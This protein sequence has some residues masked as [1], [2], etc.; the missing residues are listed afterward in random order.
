LV[1]HLR[2]LMREKLFLWLSNQRSQ[3]IDSHETGT[4]QV[5]GLEERLG[6]IR[7][8]FQD[9]MIAQEQRIAEMDRELQEKEKLLNESRKAK[10]QNGDSTK[11]S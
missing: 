1:P 5:L 10:P 4:A 7:D 8:Q 11:F 9:R 2:Q 6:K 3:L